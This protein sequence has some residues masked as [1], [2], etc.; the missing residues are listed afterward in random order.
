VRP[1]T[2]DGNLFVQVRFTDLTKE[3]AESAGPV[4]PYVPFTEDALMEPVRRIRFGRFTFSDLFHLC[5]V[6]FF[7]VLLASRAKASLGR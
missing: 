2:L 6:F 3:T 1:F 5:V 7:L 4:S